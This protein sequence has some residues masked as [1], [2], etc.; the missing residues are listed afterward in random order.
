MLRLAISIAEGMTVVGDG[1]YLRDGAVM[2]AEMSEAEW[3]RLG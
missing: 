2:A 1:S 3:G